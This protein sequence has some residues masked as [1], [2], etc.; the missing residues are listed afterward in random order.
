MGKDALIVIVFVDAFTSS[1]QRIT[2]VYLFLN[3]C[4]HYVFSYVCSKVPLKGERHYLKLN[5]VTFIVWELT[6]V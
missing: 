1:S 5:L 4:K 2:Q 3:D 6:D